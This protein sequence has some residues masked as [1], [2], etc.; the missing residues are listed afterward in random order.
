MKDTITNA[1]VSMVKDGVP[2]DDTIRRIN[3]ELNEN[4]Q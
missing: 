2:V 3:T 1:F 4:A